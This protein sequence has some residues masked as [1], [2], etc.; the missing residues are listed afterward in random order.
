M[1]CREG[2]KA[3]LLLLFPSLFF[4]CHNGPLPGNAD[5]TMQAK[6]VFELG[7]SSGATTVSWL[8]KQNYLVL[9]MSKVFEIFVFGGLF[10]IAGHNNIKS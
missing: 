1:G 5:D 6:M 2:K 4:F 3:Q 9:S 10:L 8:T 7:V